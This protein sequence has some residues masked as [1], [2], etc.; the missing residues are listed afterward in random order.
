MA[1]PRPLPFFRHVFARVMPSLLV[2]TAA[3]GGVGGLA[4]P[5]RAATNASATASEIAAAIA[6]DPSDVTGASFA[7]K[8]GGTPDAVS[9]TALTGF[10]THGASYG[11]HTSGDA[12]KAEVADTATTDN[13]ASA[14]DGGG[15]VRGD[16]DRDVSILKIDLTVPSGRNCL[17]VDF[18]FLSEE[19]QFFVGQQFNDAFIAELDNSTWATSGSTISAPNN[20]AVGPDG[21]EISVN[22]SGFGSMTSDNGNGT[23]Y[24]GGTDPNDPNKTGGATPLLIAQTPVTAG[25]HSVYFSIFDQGD[26]LYD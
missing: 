17:Q 26:N 7:A 15:A 10:P 16:T 14:D 4:A 25:P 21:K 19:F 24:S 18:Q 11:I 23:A 6:Q 12:N 1:T 5:A 20:F 8:P 3:V 2:V 9:T 22:T 13:F